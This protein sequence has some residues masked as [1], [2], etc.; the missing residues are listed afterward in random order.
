VVSNGDLAELTGQAD[1]HVVARW[2]TAARVRLR[3]KSADLLRADLEA[4]QSSKAHDCQPP[5][6]ACLG[7]SLPRVWGVPNGKLVVTD[8]EGRVWTAED[9]ANLGHVAE[10][11]AV[12]L[13]ALAERRYRLALKS[14]L[15]DQ[16]E[17]YRALV[18]A[19]AEIVWSTDAHGSVTE[20]SASWQ[21]FTGQT[22]EDC[23]G[24]GWIRAIHPED[25]LRVLPFWKD[26]ALEARPR[27][28]EYRLRHCTGR[29]RWV[30]ARSVPLF[31]TDGRVKGWIGMSQD[32][33][34]KRTAEDD[35]RRV[36]A[37]QR[38]LVEAVSAMTWSTGPDGR[39]TDGTAERWCDFTGQS[40]EDWNGRRWLEVVH[41][42]DRARVEAHWRQCETTTVE[43]EYR[44]WHRSGQWRWVKE[45]TVPLRSEGKISGWVGMTSDQHDQKVAEEA[46]AEQERRF[47][48]LVEASSEIVWTAEADGT[49][50]EDSPSWRAFTGC[51]REAFLSGGW[52]DMHPDDAPRARAEWQQM[53]ED[54]RPAEFEYRLWHRSG[55]WRWVHERATPLLADG[56]LYGWV[57]MTSDAHDRKLA[58][59]AHLEQERRFRALV[60]ASSEIVWTTEADGTIVEDSPSW[61]AF[62]G[63]SKEEWL[64]G[65]W[66]NQV[67]PDDTAKTAAIWEMTLKDGLSRESEYR[68]KHHSGTWRW[69]RERLAPL[70]SEGK[71]YGWI[72]MTSDVHDRKVAELALEE[73][74][75]RSRA[76]VEASSQI[77]WTADADG[78]IID[79][80]PTWRN[81]TGCSLAEFL[82][83]RWL[84]FIHPDEQDECLA[85]WQRTVAAGR[86]STTEYRIRHVSGEWRHML[87]HIVPLLAGDGSRRGWVGMASDVTQHRLATAALEESERRLRLALNSARMVAW[88]WD[89]RT[90]GLQFS[91]RDD[92]LMMSD[93]APTSMRD[94]CARMSESDAAL[95]RGAIET[96]VN[97]DRPF[98]VLVKVR[99]NCGRVLW[100]NVIGSAK[101]SSGNEATDAAIVVSGIFHDVTLAKT[102]QERRNLLVGEI[103]HRG[104]N[105]LAVVQSMA[106]IT[107][108]DKRSPEESRRLFLDRLASLARSHTMLTQQDWE[109]VPIDEIVEME[110]SNHMDRATV[111]VAPVLLNPSNAQSLALVM[112]E[113]VV[114]AM[115]HGALSTPHGHID[116]SGALVESSRGRVF[117]FR[118]TERD[119]P[120]VTPPTRVGF[121]SM[122]LRRLVDGFDTG[123]VIDYRRDGLFVQVDMPLDLIVPNHTSLSTAATMH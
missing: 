55:Q 2:T 108:S 49:L 12:E 15:R 95:V 87:E 110:L 29:W 53:I 107:I 104:K 68:L 28:I 82:D 3:A 83:G 54:K 105:L 24:F 116:V 120:A 69:V 34:E 36:V 19:S 81:F 79:D 77:V 74:E 70:R 91:S 56:A 118:W 76:L 100:L 121:G 20:I 103:A 31:S 44:L 90:D 8:L 16:V 22:E 23:L 17:M 123:G 66:L 112:H 62:T 67:H 86:P 1:E 38:A 85:R 94:F 46:R 43:Y 58:E 52:T 50:V 60:E 73:K 89:E 114:N 113:L 27:S 32:I 7:V 25:Q 57:G 14:R 35:L 41:P 109:G 80:S 6:S 33:H 101:I 96:S 4:N 102:A 122:L 11:L 78:R 63:C 9:V 71:I 45:R 26:G 42:D 84:A 18:E 13:G 117:R 30:H 51:S 115:K 65:E 5:S 88:T 48:A 93:I 106:G 40:L 119:G 99:A 10:S 92:M 39:L 111:D 37:E 59:L 72:G 75:E 98:E 47:R 97:D 64:R 61:R 21:K